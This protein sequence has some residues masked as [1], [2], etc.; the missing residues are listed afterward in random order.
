MCPTLSDANRTYLSQERVKSTQAR[1]FESELRLLR[2]EQRVEL[3]MRRILIA[4]RG[5]A[6]A[7]VAA[8]GTRPPRLAAGP[9][10]PI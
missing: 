7:D 1:I 2:C 4:I 6:D 8:S 3:S 9:I 5:G 10:S